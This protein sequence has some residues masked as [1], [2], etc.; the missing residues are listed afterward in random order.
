MTRV[1][2]FVYLPIKPERFD[3]FQELLEANRQHTKIESGTLE[4]SLFSVDGEPHSVAM[5]EL[6]EN[7]EASAEHDRSPALVPIL[8]QLDDFLSGAPTIMGLTY[9]KGRSD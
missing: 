9:D 3:E 2:K 4:W 1:G 7:E 8:E 5:F 6:Y